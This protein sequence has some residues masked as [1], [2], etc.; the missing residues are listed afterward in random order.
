MLNTSKNTLQ[1]FFVLYKSIKQER[2]KETKELRSF[3][4]NLLLKTGEMGRD[5]RG[6]QVRIVLIELIRQLKPVN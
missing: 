5:Y 3:K 2:H 6:E 1:Q 4:W